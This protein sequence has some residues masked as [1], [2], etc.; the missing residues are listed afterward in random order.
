[1]KRP[2]FAKYDERAEWLTDL[3]P[4][5]GKDKFFYQDDLN[6]M[7]RFSDGQA[8][9]RTDDDLEL[10]GEPELDLDD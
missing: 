4:A 9:F 10:V 8:Y 2:F 5:F 3:R 7:I 1:M 6:Q